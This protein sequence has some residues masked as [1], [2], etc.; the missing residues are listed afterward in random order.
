MNMKIDHLVVTAPDLDSGTA[1][2]ENRLGVK[3]IP[4]GQ[5]PKMG[6]H[7]RLLNLGNGVYMEVIA[8]D[9]AGT[10][11]LPRWFDMDAFP[12]TEPRLATWVAEVDDVSVFNYPMVQKLQRAHLE[13][14]LAMPT[15]G[16]VA[17]G[18]VTPP[19]IEWPAGVHPTNGMAESG[20]QLQK[21]KLFGPEALALPIADDRIEVIAAET[22][23][24]QA[25]IQTP[26]GLKT[27]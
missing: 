23:S 24:L 5:H 27:L 20:C 21:L 16:A 19:V 14:T 13:W 18:G 26:S 10:P 7:N 17:A 9:P 12:C 8:I 22:A 4:G 6:T 25:E 15:V 11:E 3:M 2:L 1:W